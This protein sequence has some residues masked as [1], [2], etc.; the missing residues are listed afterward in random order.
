MTRVVMHV[1]SALYQL[2][3]SSAAEH[4]LEM[5]S[6]FKHQ[7]LQIICLKLNKYEYMSDMSDIRRNFKW[8]IFLN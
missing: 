7:D 3:R 8:V 1:T 2:T 4:S 6:V 5:R